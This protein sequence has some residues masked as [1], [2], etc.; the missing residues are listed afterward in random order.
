MFKLL[1]NQWSS[2]TYNQTANIERIGNSQTMTPA[3]TMMIP[4]TF[5]LTS[6]F[7]K[8][9]FISLLEPGYSLIC[10]NDEAVGVTLLDTFDNNLYKSG[11]ILLQ[12]DNKILLLDTQNGSMIDQLGTAQ[13]LCYPDI[14]DGTVKEALASL[15][16]LRALLP[17]AE[18]SFHRETRIVLDDEG[19][20]VARLHSFV[21]QKDG[22]IIQFFISQPLRGYND[23]YKTLLDAMRKICP[24]KAAFYS[25]LGIEKDYYSSKPELVLDKDAPIKRTTKDIITTFIGV[26]RQNEAGIVDDHDTEFLHDYRVSLRKV[27]SAISLFKGVYCPETTEQ[28]KEKFADLMQVTGRLRD[29]DVYLLEKQYYFSLIPQSMHEGL[30][31]MFGLFEEERALAHRNI[32]TSLNSKKYLKKIKS[33]QEI[34]IKDTIPAGPLAE[35]NSLTFACKLILKRYNKVCAIARKID[36]DTNDEVVHELRIHCK[37]L[38]YLMEFFTPLFDEKKI[39]LLIKGL[40]AL[41][42]NLGRF[43]DYSVQQLSLNTFLANNHIRGK[44]LIK[45]A[46]SI[47]ALIAML[48]LLQQKE[49]GHVMENFS[50]FDS[51]ETRELFDNLFSTEG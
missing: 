24:E 9:K 51:T 32:C 40:K 36:G 41:Q 35:T 22:R 30:K 26:A 2:T 29:L 46:E 11:K 18:V 13:M 6:E 21:F 34:F 47:G 44:N 19:K 10:Q 50:Q 15:S 16:E 7:P 4:Y 27:R 8:K 31:I 17:I 45:V 38:R 28:L 33:L 12:T 25:A 1:L 49:R 39:R 37:K 3:H 42:D 43:N 5:I 23:E 14:V 48:N 20:T